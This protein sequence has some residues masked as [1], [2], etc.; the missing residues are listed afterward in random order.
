MAK[1]KIFLIIGPPVEFRGAVFPPTN[2]PE[3]RELK[4]VV[5]G[6]RA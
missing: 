4:Y 3:A 5:F 2:D 1:I 6:G